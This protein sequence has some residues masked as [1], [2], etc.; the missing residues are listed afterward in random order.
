RRAPESDVAPAGG[1]GSGRFEAHLLDGALTDLSLKVRPVSLGSRA[2][3]HVTSVLGDGVL[4]E[5]GLTVTALRLPFDAGIQV[6]D[7]VT[8]VN[9]LP[10]RQFH[11]VVLPMRR[12]PDLNPVRV[13]LARSGR[14]RTRVYR[15]R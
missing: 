3:F 15:V 2:G 6:G 14:R 7:T 5:R 11:A 8:S 4:T 1:A 12:A 10:V 13:E 9:G